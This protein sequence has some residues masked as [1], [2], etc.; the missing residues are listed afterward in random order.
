M[1]DI[2]TSRTKTLKVLCTAYNM[3]KF[4]KKCTA[5]SNLSKSVVDSKRSLGTEYIHISEL[6]QPK[7]DH[8]PSIYNLDVDIRDE[9]TY[10]D[11]HVDIHTS[12][13]RTEALSDYSCVARCAF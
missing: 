11:R 13:A 4:T 3:L 1:H 7:T 8:L 2:Y 6:D 10:T 12:R 5:E 9:Y